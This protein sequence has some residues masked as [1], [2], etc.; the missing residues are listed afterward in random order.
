MQALLEPL[1]NTAIGHSRPI[2]MI[3]LH[4][5]INAGKDTIA[6]ILCRDFGFRRIAF[7]D[8]LKDAASPLF[9]IPRHYFDDREL[10]EKPLPQWN[11]MSPR[12]LLRWLGTEILRDQFDQ[13]FLLKRARIEIDTAV[14]DAIDEGLQPRIVFTDVRFANETEFLREN[15][16]ATIVKVD[17]TGNPKLCP[18]T[19]HNDSRVTPIH[20]TDM[21]LPQDLVHHVIQNDGSIQDLE[22]KVRMLMKII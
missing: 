5:P 3:G 19:S 20:R 11:G 22:R 2:L 7:A 15:F 17:P 12:D 18:D 16:G 21:G 1:V 9:G 8:P 10:K 6:A 14:L 4:G 13:D